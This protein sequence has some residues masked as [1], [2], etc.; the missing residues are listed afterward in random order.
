M[1]QT[2]IEALQNPAL[3]NHPTSEF[4]LYQTHI[5]WVLLTGDY[6]YKIKKPMDFGFLN[7]T[8][9]EKRRFFCEQEV[10]LNQRLAPEIY[11]DVLP[12]SGTESEPRLGDDSAPFEYAVRMKQF[13]A[14]RLLSNLQAE[15]GLNQD[16]IDV[17]AEQIAQFHQRINKADSSTVLGDADQVMLPVQ[18]NFDQVRALLTKKT[19]LAQLEQ[20]EGWAQDTFTRLR[21]LFE[22]RKQEGMIRECHGDIHLGNVALIGD[23][24]TLF[25]CIEFND[26][27][28]WI[29]V[30]SEVA[31]LVMDLESRGEQALARHFI[32]HYLELTG[33]YEG[34]Q[35]LSFYKSYRAMVRAKVSR[36]ML[37]DPSLSDEARANLEADYQRYIDLA[38]AYTVFK[39][40]F[41]LITNGVSGSGKSWI[42]RAVIKELG[43][44]RIRSDVERKRLFGLEANADSHSEL[45]QGIYTPEATEKT[46]QRLAE[47]A[48]FVIQSATPVIIDATNLKLWQ[49]EALREKAEQ[50]AVPVLI[51]SFTASEETLRR[52]VLKRHAKG[53]DASEADVAVLEKQL[54]QQETISA[55][56]ASY[57]VTIN[58]DE[59]NASQRLLDSIRR[60]FGLQ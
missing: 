19:A 20:L 15:S 32:N 31:F 33:D 47:L 11:L 8:T 7:F 49:R 42:S 27:F 13:D 29:D 6:A 37:G 4:R 53:D 5:S 28:R 14:E 18:Q 58:T 48:G 57:T 35:L 41:M 23:Q 22:R 54:Q 40:P 26:E 25:D 38:E 43:V 46:Y 2:L 34:I 44:I 50:L 52:R 30:I 39:H 24:V 10:R 3:Y 36:F 9:L 12:I 55:E 21:P 59:D 1:S 16:H 60:N 56:E 17:M 51:L 45:E